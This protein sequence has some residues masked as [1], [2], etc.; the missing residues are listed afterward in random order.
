MNKMRQMKKVRLFLSLLLVLGIT[1]S[2]VLILTKDIV[3]AAS[4]VSISDK[5]LTLEVDHYQTLRVKGASGSIS[6]RSSNTSV[7]SVTSGGK[8][9]AKTPGTST[10]TAT[11]NGKKL[12]CKLSVIYVRTTVTLNPGKTTTLTVSGTKSVPEWTS[13]NEDVATVSDKGVVTAIKPGTTTIYSYVDGKTCDTKVTVASMNVT[14]VVLEL[15]GWSGYV[16]TLKVEGISGGASWSSS[17]NAIATVAS[18]GK[19][20]AKGYGTATITAKINGTSLSTKV[21]VLKLSTKEFDLKLG[22]TN[23]LKIYGTSS[24]I[25]WTSNQHSVVTVTAD[26]TVTAVGVGSA[27]ITGYVEGREMM[28]IVNVVK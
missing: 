21:I 19:V 15:N 1:A 27:Y 20:T 28:A 23:K 11:A 17:N 14:N 7:A 3:W 4:A 5:T 13:T 2:T 18:N 22:K 24:P 26:G 25:T 6:W 16:K 8:V 10:I 9:T 12:T